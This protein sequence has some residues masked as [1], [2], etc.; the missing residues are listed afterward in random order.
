MIAT[1]ALPL[2]AL[3]ATGAA[4]VQVDHYRHYS[5]GGSG[6]VHLLAVSAL[7]HVVGRWVDRLPGSGLLIVFIIAA[8]VFVVG[9]HHGRRYYRRSRGRY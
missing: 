2:F 9:G 7:W 5:A 6:L 8:A 3:A 1:P 4:D